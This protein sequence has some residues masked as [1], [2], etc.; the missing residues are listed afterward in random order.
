[1]AN[2]AQTRLGTLSDEE[3]RMVQ[4]HRE[5]QYKASGWRQGVQSAIHVLDNW[6]PDGTVTLEV[7]VRGL[8]SQL[9][10]LMNNP[11]VY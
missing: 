6:K 10:N 11:K 9:T 2:E 7:S 5:D 4:K 1:M 3:I 8:R